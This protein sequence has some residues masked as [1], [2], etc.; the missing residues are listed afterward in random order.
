[1]L[2]GAVGGDVVVAVAGVILFA[3]LVTAV[4][5]FGFAL[6]SVPL[7]SLVIDIHTAVVV[8]SMVSVCANGVQAFVDRRYRDGTLIRRLTLACFIGLPFGYLVYRAVGDTALRIVLGAGVIVAVALLSRG[9]NLTHVGP[10][11]DWAMGIISGVLSTSISTS[12]PPLVFDL[13]ARRLDPN[14]FRATIQAVFLFAGLAGLVLFSV[15]GDIGRDELAISAA[16]VPALA[17]GLLLGFPLRRRV[18]GDR[19]RVLVNVLL[20]VSAVAAV[21]KAFT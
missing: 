6:M 16:A 13:Q 15:G 14:V 5:G 4:A 17:A 20:T 7:M 11:L 21:S 3:S 10:G 8:S 2:F 9:L 1:M 12:G 18:T 19:F